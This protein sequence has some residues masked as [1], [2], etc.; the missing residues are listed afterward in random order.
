MRIA[1]I[2]AGISGLAAALKL[3]SH[4]AVTLFEA[5]PRLGGHAHSVEITLDGITAPVDT[6]FLVYN[7][8]TYPNL[9]ALFDEL[10]VPTAPSDMSF[11]V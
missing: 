7:D 11:S 8:R 2:G 4:H 3:S 1:V 10:K 6:G 5:Q 9:I